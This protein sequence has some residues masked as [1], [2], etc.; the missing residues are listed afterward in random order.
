M[1][2]ENEIVAREFVVADL[3]FR[4][5]FRECCAQN[6]CGRYGV[7]PRC[8]PTCGTVEEMRERVLRFS[9]GVLLMTHFGSAKHNELAAAWIAER[10]ADGELPADGEVVSAGPTASASCMSAY[11]IDAAELMKTVGLPF[12]WKA[13]EESYLT[14]YLFQR[15]RSSESRK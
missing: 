15:D 1:T 6:H 9:H 7:H 2:N 4:P 3:V 10:V 8:P 5:E 13:G 12:S 14:L 11:C